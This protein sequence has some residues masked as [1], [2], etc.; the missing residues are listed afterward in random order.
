MSA[1]SLVHP[2]AAVRRLDLAGF[3]ARI[4][5][6]SNDSARISSIEGLRGL[7][8]TLI[9][10]GHFDVQFNHLLAP[11][12]YSSS[13]AGV[14]ALIGHRGVA[15]FLMI[16]GY[17]VYGKFMDRPEPYLPFVRKRLVRVYPF[18][19]LILTIYLALSAIFPSESKLPHDSLQAA[20]YVLQNVLPFPGIVSTHPVMVVSWTIGYLVSFYIALPLLVNGLRMRAWRPA[21]RVVFWIAM[22]ALWLTAAFYVPQLNQRAVYLVVGILVYETLRAPAN[23]LSKQGELRSLAAFIAGFALLFLMNANRLSFLPYVESLRSV[24]WHVFMGAGL[25]C[26]GRYCIGFEGFI[27]SFFSCRPLRSLGQI[28]YSF[29]LIHGLTL[30]AFALVA[31]LLL[32]PSYHSAGLF[33]SSAAIA[34]LAALVASTLTFVF[35]EQNLNAL[36]TLG[37]REYFKSLD[38]RLVAQQ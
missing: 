14:L 20:I 16:T 24:Y 5:P 8:M 1:V 19:L 4:L 21:V 25:Y 9:F 30:K 6:L 12:T 37:I 22:A 2:A 34:Y 35:V 27:K 36:G 7:A 32:P 31:A 3:L 33:W 13:L 11:G 28:G 29:Y 15:F 23:K 10:F 17:F 38:Q 26:F 18:Y